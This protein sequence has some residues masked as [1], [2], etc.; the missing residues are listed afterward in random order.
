[1]SNFRLVDRDTG[2][3]DAAVGARVAT[4]AAPGALR[5]GGDRGTCGVMLFNAA[6][7][8]CFTVGVATPIAAGVFYGVGGTVSLRALAVGV[9]F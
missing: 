4:A 2:F 3:S 7:R 6:A 9:V 8:A 5:G 1:M